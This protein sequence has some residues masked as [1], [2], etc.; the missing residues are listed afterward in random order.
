MRPRQAS[1]LPP[2]CL[3][4]RVSHSHL[5]HHLFLSL[6]LFRLF[7]HLKL[8]R[9]LLVC[10]GRYIHIHKTQADSTSLDLQ[11]PI[12]VHEPAYKVEFSNNTGGLLHCSGHANPYP[13]V[14][15]V[16]HTPQLPMLRCLVLLRPRKMAKKRDR[17]SATNTTTSTMNDATM[18]AKLT[19]MIFILSRKQS[20]LPLQ[21]N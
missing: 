3:H 19:R 16:A 8:K 6:S 15:H 18:R 12:F 10:I 2:L 11:G 7:I 1:F 13:E 20:F 4:D 5:L 14:I 17:A 9:D 21:S